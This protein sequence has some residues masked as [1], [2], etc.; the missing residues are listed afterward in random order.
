MKL[1][2]SINEKF[3][4]IDPHQFIDTVVCVDKEKNISGF[5][6]FFDYKNDEHKKYIDELIRLSIV[7]NYLIQFHA[8]GIYDL[9][10]QKVFLD[11]CSKV[12][13]VNY[14]IKIV[15]HPY[16]VSDE[17]DAVDMTD[18]YIAK[19]LEYAYDNDYNLEITV[20]NLNNDEGEIRL[21]HRDLV[22]IL[23]NNKNLMFTYDIGHDIF[24]GDNMF[25]LDS[26]NV[27]RLKNVHIHTFD[28]I[29]DH[30]P[31]DTDDKN[32]DKWMKGI[33]ILKNNNYEGTV[34]LENMI[35]INLMVIHV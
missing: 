11:Y 2:L 19:L 6:F 26:I 13:S 27:S 15:Y 29:T 14:Q 28:E 12:S 16:S 23:K 10:Y 7:N 24:E 4:E 1:M 3:F 21:N 9:D 25:F 22:P 31:I 35:Y 33:E 5:E 30:I 18:K 20:E 32:K 8:I 34:V 17:Y